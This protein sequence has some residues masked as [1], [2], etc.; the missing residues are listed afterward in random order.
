MS[1]TDLERAPE[2]FAGNREIGYFIP[3]ATFGYLYLM[4]ANPI[5]LLFFCLNSACSVAVYLISNLPT[6][7]ITLDTPDL[8]NSILFFYTFAIALPAGGFLLVYERSVVPAKI[9]VDEIGFI[10]LLFL[11][12]GYFFGG[13]VAGIYYDN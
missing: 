5:Y 11:N 12:I 6:H 3:V 1:V 9:V 2:I 7:D 10:I 8:L 4:Q 13:I